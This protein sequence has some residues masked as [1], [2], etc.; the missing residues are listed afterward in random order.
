M[1]TATGTHTST[2]TG[3][4]TMITT[5]ADA[6]DTATLYRLLAF[7]SPAFPI[8]A[9]TY[10]HGLEQVI[11]EGDVRDAASLQ[12][13][14]QDVLTHGAGRS[15]GIL[16]VETLRAAHSGDRAAVEDLIELGLALQPSKERHLESSAQ[17][18]AFMG[19]V[20]AAWAPEATTPASRLL[21]NLTMGEDRIET[22]PYPVAVGL[23]AAAWAVPEDAI[24][25]AFLHAFAANMVSVAIRAVPLGQSDGQR[26]LAAAQG[27]IATLTDRIRASG[28][29]DLGTAGLLTDI[30][31]MAHET[32][33]SR[34]FRS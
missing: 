20:T 6:L 26:C 29:E 10:S 28:L 23:V 5:M 13:W 34:L 7:L 30:A 4:I 1:T 33:Y 25:T 27:R 9:F 3:I 19:A 8:G 18:T 11:D 14:L 21:A 16:L 22:W 2:I 12:A 31:S 32:K 15:D 17:G 24:L